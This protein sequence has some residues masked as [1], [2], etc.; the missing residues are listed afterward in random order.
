VAKYHPVGTGPF[1]FVSF[2]R[3]VNLKYVRWDGYWQ[4]GKPYLDGVEFVYI[5]DPMVMMASFKA[6]EGNVLL[7]VEPKDAQSLES[8]GKYAISKCLS[9]MQGL[10]GDGS[11][12]ESPFANLKVRQAIEFAVNREP[13]CKAVGAGYFEAT[14]QSCAK[15]NWGYNPTPSPYKY[16]P[17]KA[18]TLLTEA[19]YRTVWEDSL[20]LWRINRLHRLIFIPR[21]W[22][23]LIM[24][25]LT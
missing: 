15:S 7:S 16:D 4:A 9:G 23:S 18:K 24:P 25:A 10:V 1:K 5:A 8:T 3:D 20:S 6:G 19:G 12:P 21:Y 11:H 13:V 2:Q 22:S 14:D 17:A